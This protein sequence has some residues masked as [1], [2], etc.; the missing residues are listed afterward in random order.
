MTV[1]T[2]EFAQWL[3]TIVIS[4]FAGFAFGLLVVSGG[5]RF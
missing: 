4:G 5:V 1:R 3:G 2:I